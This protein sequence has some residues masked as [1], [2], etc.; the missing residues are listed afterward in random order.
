MKV[1]FF[2]ECMVE[3]SG[4]PLRRTFGG[5]TLNTALYLA[6]LGRNR[7]IDVSYATGLGEDKLSVEMKRAWNDEYIDTSLIETVSDKQP[8]LY[9]VET[10]VNGERTFL[11]WRNDSAAKYYF[12]N[13]V[14]KLEVA[15][16]ANQHDALYLSGI[17]LAI[18][19][20]S[21]RKRMLT[22]AKHHHESGKKVIFD[23]NFRPQLWSSSDARQWYEKL[24][25]YVDIALL[26]EDDDREIWGTEESIESRCERFEIAEVVIKRGCEPCKVITRENNQINTHIVAASKVA[27]VIDTCA[28]G[29]S[30]AAGYLSARLSG[31]SCELS[32]EFAHSVAAIVIQ[33]PGA[34]APLGA[35]DHLL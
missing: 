35:M 8:G 34:I 20:N 17:S 26:T 5:D 24:L 11:Y 4:E 10:D 33:H 18:L 15:L 22:M 9:L 2:G 31:Q 16:A 21:A 23:N 29:D 30:F 25:P 1:A 14:S 27:N 6:R 13:V 28:A 19:N 12:D 32:A 7:G 3:L